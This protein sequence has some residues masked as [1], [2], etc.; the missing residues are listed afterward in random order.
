MGY[1]SINNLYKDQT[2]LLFRRCY[3]LEKVHGSSAHISWSDKN[4]HYF[5]GGESQTNFK[6]LFDEEALRAKF[7]ALGH[8]KMTIFGEVYGGRC[9]KMSHT[10]GKDLR[11]IV[12]DIHIGDY[13]LTVPQM[14]ALAKEFGLEVVPWRE[15]STD[16]AELDA[17]RDLPSEV[18]VRRGCGEKL[19]E[20]VVLRPLV[21]FTRNGE[22]VI[23]KHKRA[24]FSECATPQK[25]VSPEKLEVLTEA[26]AI[27]DQWVTEQRLSNILSHL[28]EPHEMK[29]TPRIIQLM[30]DDVYKEG[31]GEFTDSKE[32]KAAIGKKAAQLYKKRITQLK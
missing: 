21:E 31:K 9:Q 2:I 22:R 1:L 26:T 18:A 13:W 19:R 32:V 15:I 4:V 3:A 17:E 6:A 7:E 27:A 12:F 23:C 14:D 28:P 5:A 10:Y 25:V 20:G 16:L 24:E 30:V 29:D 11:F 8:P